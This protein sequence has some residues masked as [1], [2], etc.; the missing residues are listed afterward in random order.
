MSPRLL[1]E[2][3]R[4]NQM[5]NNKVLIKLVA[6]HKPTFLLSSMKYSL[7]HSLTHRIT[8]HDKLEHRLLVIYEETTQA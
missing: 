1:A 3:K 8:R 7:V 4:Q 2:T 6:K 5:H